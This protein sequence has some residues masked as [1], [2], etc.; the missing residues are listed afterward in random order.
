MD[1]NLSFFVIINSV[2]AFKK[3]IFG[4][5]SLLCFH[6]FLPFGM[7]TFLFK[8]SGGALLSTFVFPRDSKRME[9]MKE[10]KKVFR[11]RLRL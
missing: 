7:T 8:Q 2:S 4:E 5:E 11:E 9:V 6:R 3:W 10:P 1:I